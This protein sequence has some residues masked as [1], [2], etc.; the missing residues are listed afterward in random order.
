MFNNWEDYYCYQGKID[1]FIQLE[2]I[3]FGK[4][5]NQ[6]LRE[7]GDKYYFCELEKIILKQYVGVDNPC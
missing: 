2:E 5:E 4:V 6:F 3:P 1:E 7:Y